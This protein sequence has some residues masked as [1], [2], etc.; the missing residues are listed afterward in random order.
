MRR[1]DRHRLAVVALLTLAGGDLPAHGQTPLDPPGSDA[2]PPLRRDPV[3]P[4]LREDERWRES[5]FSVRINGY[6]VSDGAFFIEDPA[7][8]R[9][10]VELDTAREWRLLIDTDKV[11]T[12][13]GLP[14]YPL[15]AIPGL[16]ADLDRVALGLGLDIP[17]DQFETY[18]VDAGARETVDAGA[19]HGGFLDY[20]LL[21]TEGEDVER[22]LEG[23]AEF[24]VFTPYGVA[25]S[26]FK[27]RTLLD[28]PDL[29][30]L[31]TSFTRDFPERRT[32]LTLGDSSSIGGAFGTGIRFGGVHLFTDFGLD[33]GFVPFP[34][35]AIGGLAEQRSLV[36]VLVDNLSRTSESVPPGPFEFNN[37]PVVSG[38]GEV[39]L[40]VRDLLGRE[41]LITRDYYV[42]PR[43]LRRSLHDYSYV[44]GV[45]REEYAIKD[46]D[47][48]RPILSATHRY[49]LTSGVTGEFHAEA[50]PDRASLVLGGVLG[51]G[52]FGL[53]S[54]GIGVSD[55]ED[56]GRG[57]V[58][59]GAYEYTGRRFDAGLGTRYT[60]EDFRQ[61][62]DRGVVGRTDQLSFG[63]NLGR[64]GRVGLL[65]LNRVLI[66]AADVRS[67]SLSYSAPFGPGSFIL[68]AA[69]SIEPDDAAA[70][71]ATYALPLGGRR[72][73]AF[74][75]EHGDDGSRGAVQYRQARDRTDLGLDWRAALEADEDGNDKGLA[76]DL[77][78]QTGFAG[79][80]LE[81]EREDGST[82]ARAGVSG[83]V[84][85][86]GGD[87]FASRR[88]GRGFGLVELPGFA[89]VRVYVDNREVGRTNDEGR[90]LLPRLRPYQPNKVS[91]AVEDLPIDAR[92]GATEQ[93]AAP[94]AR[95]GVMIEMP[96]DGTDRS[97]ATLRDRDGAPLPAGTRLVSADGA[98]VA[99]VAKDGFAQ[100]EG[101][102]SGI[103]AIEGSVRGRGFV[104][105]LPPLIGDDPLPDRGEISCVD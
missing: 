16:T 20:D 37:L 47:Y 3:R 99:L 71:T 93:V 92:V 29:V 35:P 9:L 25:L 5:I 34:L 77:D 90:L 59:Q 69:K 18:V 28:V 66:D 10:A 84:V 60:Q 63:L 67:T 50:E 61:F 8:G 68:N 70:I 24:G 53:A 26:S 51:I 13:Q 22:R 42:S 83:S 2:V 89:D 11:L 94:A 6:P 36:D 19:D 40:R 49:G 43:L 80:T 74:R 48:D 91:F 15:D 57:V 55:D 72:S 81:V 98:V 54:G 41:R 105:P 87:L 21:L 95:S 33:P 38:A 4:P 30:R 45:A 85:Y 82:A 103:V 7:G 12:F 75:V 76:V 101:P 44:L 32:G 100:I 79:T 58:A 31:E 97:L 62:G 46:F 102:Q 52:R 96:V 27:A 78:Y 88:L 39:Q 73:S 104:C 64:L 17:A 65:F 14:F 86:L 23:L 1:I 56:V